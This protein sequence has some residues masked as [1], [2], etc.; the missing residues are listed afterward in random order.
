MQKC[1]MPDW[2][3]LRYL[4]A[5]H[6]G[7]TLSA[8][9]RK[10]GVNQTTVGRRLDAL[11]AALGARL[12]R[13]ASDGYFLTRDGERALAHAERIEEEMH[14][15]ERDITGDDARPE[16]VVRLTT[17][18][19]LGIRF[20]APWL[21]R[22]R[23]RYPAIDV[24]LNLDN[25]PLNLSRRE[26]DLAVRPSRPTQAALQIRKIGSIAAGLYA[27]PAYLER[28]GEPRSVD[29]LAGHDFIADEETNAHYFIQRWML[30]LAR[31]APV[32]LRCNLASAQ[33]A[34]AAD[35]VGIAA[36][37]CYLGDAERGLRR[38]LPEEE[39]VSDLWL[40]VHRDLQYAARVRALIDFLVEIAARD[41]AV[42][43]GRRHR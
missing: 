18:E 16:G 5:I 20:V 43:T 1:S 29:D 25:R 14:A 38:V 19:S 40:A 42:L 6:R 39:L 7:H 10:L 4:L 41:A 35:G 13:R 2:T 15:L 21:G 36:L 3:D 9:A 37:Y 30:R 31:G 22:F 24:Q 26:A 8:A 23:A 11:E 34:A 12:F 28:R 32:A 27:S 17:F 33:A